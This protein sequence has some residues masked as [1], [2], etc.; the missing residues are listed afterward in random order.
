MAGELQASF[1]TGKTC[2]FL[3]RNRNAQISNVV[4]SGFSNYA[5]AA[6]SGYPI[7]ANEQ[8]SASAYYTGNIPVYVPPGIYSAVLKQQIGANPAEGDPTVDVGDIN[9]NGTNVAQLSDI[10]V[11][12]STIIL[13][14]RSWQILNYPFDLRS[15]TDHITPFTSGTVS[16]Q[17]ARDNGAWG[18]LQSGAFTEIGFGTYVLQ[19]LTSGDTNANT[20]SLRFT[21]VN[22][23]GG[24]ACDPLT[25]HFILQRSSGS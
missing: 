18:P 5:T 24:G 11:S 9:W 15:S 16:G 23:V 7:G 2:Y 1:V 19:A 20:M 14:P 17:I 13:L 10:S 25:Q 22:A 12:G 4:V 21:A 8:G 6:Y 3:L